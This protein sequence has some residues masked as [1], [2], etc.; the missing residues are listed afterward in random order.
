MAHLDLWWRIF[1]KV[2][3]KWVA[4]ELISGWQSILVELFAKIVAHF[5]INLVAHFPLKSGAFE[6]EVVGSTESNKTTV[7]HLKF[8]HLP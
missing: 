3:L 1:Q 6:I 2:K 4:T 8:T 5:D 7:H